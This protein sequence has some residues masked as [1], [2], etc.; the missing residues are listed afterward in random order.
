MSSPYGIRS[1]GSFTKEHA[2]DRASL[3]K[4]PAR[5]RQVSPVRMG[6]ASILT[7]VIALCLAVLAVLAVSTASA[8]ANMAERQASFVTDDYANEALGQ[9][10]Y[11]QADDVVAGVHAQGGS[12]AD[13]ASALTTALPEFTSHEG[14]TASVENNTLVLHVEAPS[15]RCLDA[16]LAITSEVTLSVESWKA[17]TTW[18]DDNTDMLWTGQ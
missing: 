18:V 5:S 13:A 12:A 14:V 17:T 15:G 6:P 2:N 3:M 8:N 16:Q 9:E 10:L 1:A 7:L 11:A 4:S